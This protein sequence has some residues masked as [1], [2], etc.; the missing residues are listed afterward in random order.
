MSPSEQLRIGDAEREQAQSRLSDHY[1][2]GRL[3][4]DEYSQ[5]LDQVWAAR[6]RAE[7][8][9]VFGDLPGPGSP[10]SGPASYPFSTP[11]ARRPTTVRRPRGNRPPAPLLALLV[12]LGVV[13]GDDSPAVDP[14]RP[15]RVV[16]LPARRR[17]PRPGGADPTVVR[18]ADSPLLAA[19]PSD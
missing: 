5:R 6:T 15:G 1:A 3:D 17:L 11:D 14:G 4:H 10:A 12:V 13:R 16:L 2:A 8:D 9:P 19:A 18:R 7:L